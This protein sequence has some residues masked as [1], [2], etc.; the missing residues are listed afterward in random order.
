MKLSTK[1]FVFSEINRK[2][3]NGQRQKTDK[4]IIDLREI[5]N[6]NQMIETC[7]LFLNNIEYLSSDYYWRFIS[8]DVCANIPQL[9]VI[10]RVNIAK[11]LLSKPSCE[12][13]DGGGW[14]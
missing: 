3:R 4:L 12:C 7:Y 14:I 1:R 5:Q 10:L 9:I 6:L 11:H 13:I 2:E 8:Y